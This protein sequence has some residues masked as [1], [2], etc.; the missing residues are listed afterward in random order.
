MSMIK[1][2]SEILKFFKTQYPLNQHGLEELF[3][4][5]KINNYKK[6]SII[7]KAS[8]KEKQLRFLNKGT[9]REYYANL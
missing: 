6:G 9:V 4:L 2:N 3:N 8:E 1:N 5:F 7:L